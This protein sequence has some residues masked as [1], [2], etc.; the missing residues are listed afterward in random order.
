MRKRF[1]G[2]RAGPR[3]GCAGMR[4]ELLL[5]HLHLHLHLLE[6]LR[7]RATRRREPAERAIT[8]RY[9]AAA[10]VGAAV[11]HIIVDELSCR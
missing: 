8:S 4:H 6:W 2:A 9:C 7:L 10:I 11:G 1:G 5:L 3:C